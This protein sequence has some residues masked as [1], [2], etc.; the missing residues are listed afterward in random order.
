MKH[1]WPIRHELAMIDGISMKGKGIIIIT[2]LL[3]RQILEQLHS[4]HMGFKKMS[5]L[6]RETV[7]LMKMNADIKKH[8][9][10]LCQLL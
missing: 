6:V 2:F 8:H 9:K 3:Q 7:Y 10:A 1:H 5:H 4:Y